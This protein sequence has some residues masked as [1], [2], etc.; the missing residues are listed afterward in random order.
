MSYSRW[1]LFTL[2]EISELAIAL[3]HRLAEAERRNAYV[4]WSY[5]GDLLREIH[6][7]RDEPDE[8]EKIGER[9]RDLANA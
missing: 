4:W 8:A 5:V 9:M 6:A 2:E 3:D 7:Y 1:D